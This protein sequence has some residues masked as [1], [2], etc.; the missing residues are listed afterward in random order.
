[1][2]LSRVKS[3]EGLHLLKV[4]EEKALIIDPQVKEFYMHILDSDYIFSWECKKGNVDKPLEISKHNTFKKKDSEVQ[5]KIISQKGRPSRYPNGSKTVRIPTELIEDIDDI[6][7]IVCPKA[8]MDTDALHEL[9]T[10]LRQYIK[11]YK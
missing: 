7:Q 6:L 5:G 8:G 1:M 4:I 10:Q 3:I 2:L 11:N 9:Q